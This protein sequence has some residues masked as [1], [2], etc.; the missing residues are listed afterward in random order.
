VVEALQHL[1]EL[2]IRRILVSHGEPVLEDG[3]EALA[4]ALARSS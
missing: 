2:P 1:L 3:G 4:R